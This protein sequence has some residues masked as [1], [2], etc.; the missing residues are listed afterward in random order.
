MKSAIPNNVLLAAIR[1][2]VSERSAAKERE[3]K[4]SEKLNAQREAQSA[5]E[6]EESRLQQTLLPS[7][8]AG[9]R[10][11]MQIRTRLEFYR[12][13]LE[14]L[15][16]QL[17]AAEKECQECDGRVME[18]IK[19]WAGDN[20]AK[21]R[22]AMTDAFAELTDADFAKWAAERAPTVSAAVRFALDPATAGMPAEALAAFI[23]ERG[24]IPNLPPPQL[25]D[26][27]MVH[28]SSQP[29]PQASVAQ[30]RTIIEVEGKAGR[31]VYY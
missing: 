24:E 21:K 31:R 8:A 7:D 13:P 14:D 19:N 28:F 22:A 11:L 29:A 3:A 25:A 18:A 20:A 16:K 9:I 23:L 10:E 17:S 26:A 4:I 27:G 5:D 1:T 6:A 12:R 2:A 30:H 15:Q